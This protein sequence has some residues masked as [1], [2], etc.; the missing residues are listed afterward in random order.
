MKDLILFGVQ[1]CGK[2]TQGRILAE[3]KGY[4]VFE[5]GKELRALVAG[6]SELGKKI[7]DIIEAGN[8]VPDEV[9]I[10]IVAHFLENT[11]ADQAI[12]F[13]GL[14]RKESQRVLFEEVVNKFARMPV[15]ILIH[16]ADEV[17]LKRL[18]DRHMSKSTGKIYPNKDAALA[19]CDEEDVYQRTDDVPEAIK[20]RLETYHAETQP[21]IDWYTSEGRMFEFDGERTVEEVTAELLEKLV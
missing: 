1:G 11:E 15:G 16:I 5:T 14:P 17:S 3:R 18:G 20:T 4:K 21:V 19:E 12:I 2:G 7:K 13:D 8:L 9:V 10:E 6:G